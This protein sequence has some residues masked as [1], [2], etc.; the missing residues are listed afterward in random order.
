MQAGRQARHE[1]HR[2]REGERGDTQDAAESG[3]RTQVFS[4]RTA[5]ART[6]MATTFISP[7]ATRSAISAQQH[8]RQKAPW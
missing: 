6:T 2:D 5:P 1:D 4:A 3:P 8:A 7:K